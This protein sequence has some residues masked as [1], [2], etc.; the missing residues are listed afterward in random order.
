MATFTLEIVQAVSDWQRGGGHNAKVKR[1]AALKKACAGL[2]SSFRTW[3]GFCYRQEAHEKDRVWQLL[4][5]NCLTETI[6]AW[7]TDLGIA[8][9]F[10]GGVAPEGLQG[11]IFKLRP[12]SASVVVNLSALFADSD[13]RD[14][15]DLYGKQIAGFDSGIG[16][17]RDSQK[18]VV[19]E[20]ASLDR[21]STYALG[22]Y[23][24]SREALAALLFGR[25]PSGE[26]LKVFGELC[27]RANVSAGAWWLTEAGTRA[28]LK[29]MEPHVA[30]LRA[31]KQA[32]TTAPTR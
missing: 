12:P 7:T 20:I 22:G 10:K 1:G 32:A 14:A 8:K 5:D 29:R 15:C 26:D 13:F 28:V 18:E 24:G 27:R 6:A 30:R 9:T 11:V 31:Q 17:Y 16:R 19:L 25:P 21:A 4:A 2:P 23:S 3:D